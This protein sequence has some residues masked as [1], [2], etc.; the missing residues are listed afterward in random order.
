MGGATSRFADTA[1]DQVHGG[2]KDPSE[3][4]DGLPPT[5]SHSILTLRRPNIVNQ[6]HFSILDDLDE[7]VYTSMPVEG[8]TR[9]FDFLGRNGTKLFRVHATDATHTSWIV[10]AYDKPVFDDQVADHSL[11]EGEITSFG[12]PLFRKARIDIA[13]DK[14]AGDVKLYGLSS[15]DRRGDIVTIPGDDLE[16]RIVLKV[17]EIKS[18]TAQFQSYVP[19]AYMPQP[20]LADAVVHPPLVGF[21]VWEHSANRHQIKMHLARGTDTALQCLVAIITNQVYVETQTNQEK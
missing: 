19:S 10:F 7:V 9:D 6:R 2:L 8:T 17:E 1:W 20:N 3:T 5:A 4:I 13:W 18:Y 11:A 12:H 21:W 16:H 14:H 15:E